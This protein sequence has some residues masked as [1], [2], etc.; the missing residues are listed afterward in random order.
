[1]NSLVRVMAAVTYLLVCLFTA[2]PARADA[3][4]TVTIWCSELLTPDVTGNQPAKVAY[5]RAEEQLCHGKFAQARDDFAA[6]VPH[7]AKL[8]TDG[9]WWINTARGYFYSLIATRDDARARSFLTSL[10]TNNQWKPSQGDRRFWEGDLR[11][12]F[13]D[14]ASKAGTISGM[15][16]D[17]RE[18]NID[19]AA[20]ASGDLNAAITILQK[21]SHAYG[22]G[23]VGSLQLLM[24]GEA[25]ET[26]RRWRDA[27]ATWVRAADSGHEVMEYDFYDQWNLSALEMIYY[28]RAHIPTDQRS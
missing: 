16:G 19:D 25:Y 8:Q 13:T 20:L 9:S 23:D 12:A 26:Q 28:Y 14:Y 4:Q 11:A 6:I 27:F 3:K 1:M 2:P 17:P 18:Q 22:P 7:W 10:Q 15:S 24:L 5:A 21:P